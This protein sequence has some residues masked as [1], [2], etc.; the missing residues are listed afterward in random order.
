MFDPGL[1]LPKKI[2]SFGKKEKMPIRPL[3]VSQT[4]T[5]ASSLNDK[6][7]FIL[8]K[9]T[10]PRHSHQ[11]FLESDHTNSSSDNVPFLRIQAANFSCPPISTTPFSSSSNNTLY[12]YALALVDV[13]G[14]VSSRIVSV[15][16]LHPKRTVVS[17]HGEQEIDQTK[18]DLKEQKPLGYRDAKTLLGTSFGTKQT[19]SAIASASRHQID[20]DALENQD[21]SFT[22]H[23]AIN[24]KQENNILASG[25]AGAL[26]PPETRPQSPLSLQDGSKASFHLLPPHN[27]TT[28]VLAEVYPIEYSL[29]TP[30]LLETL[31][32]DD[33]LQ[34]EDQGDGV[35]SIGAVA[36]E[37]MK[38]LSPFVA[39]RM[40][41][42]LSAKAE[43]KELD[44]YNIKRMQV[45][46]VLL[47]H[48]LFAF[49][50]LKESQ[51]NSEAAMHRACFGCHNPQV[52]TGFLRDA[53]TE[54]VS[55]GPRYKL[56]AQAKDKVMVWIG[57][58]CLLLDGHFRTNLTALALQCQVSPLKMTALMCAAGCSIE[59]T[60]SSK[61]EPNS[62]TTMIAPDGRVLPVKWA[63][64]KA[65]LSET[66]WPGQ[67]V[68]ARA[69]RKRHARQ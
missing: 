61:K 27:P 43:H 16:L 32:I 22:L 64:L 23:G 21:H 6:Q 34:P 9:N 63:V 25:G 5:L 35:D 66:T 46:L 48:Y 31:P 1:S 10:N 49:K 20:V 67:G 52:M 4:D 33:F 38:F 39:S 30:A 13:N 26:T 14:K 62:S 11:L 19:K 58:V 59:A 56:P 50:G 17:S 8:A 29:L 53:F 7:R 24:A 40:R 57:I 51:V 42:V 54:T 18:T 44:S 55:P 60:P 28:S 41:Q 68:K 12:Q 65:P 36:E 69:G 45:A 2:D 15:D 3:V 37:A 47:L